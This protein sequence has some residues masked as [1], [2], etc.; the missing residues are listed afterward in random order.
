V[1]DDCFALNEGYHA[2]ELRHRF[3]DF[4]DRNYPVGRVC[5]QIFFGD[6]SMTRYTDLEEP[7]NNSFAF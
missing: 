2:S 6:G 7:S 5:A 3:R 4:G 1:V